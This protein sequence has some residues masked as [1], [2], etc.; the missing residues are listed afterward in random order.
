MTKQLLSGAPTE[1]SL[2]RFFYL[3]FA[4]SIPLSLAG[5]AVGLELLPGLPISSLVATCCPLITA[6]ILVYSRNGTAGVTGLLKRAFDIKR[7]QARIWYAPIVL[8]MSGAMILAYG[9]M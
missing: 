7:V 5:T 4:L 2:L 1:R 9:L 3:V 6:S 8:R